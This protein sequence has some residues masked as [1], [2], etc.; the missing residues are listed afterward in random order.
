MKQLSLWLALFSCAV[1]ASLL[2]ESCT[3][4]DGVLDPQSLSKISTL[5][6]EKTSSTTPAA[7]PAITY[8]NNG[9]LMVMNADGS[10]QAVI[11]TA[12]NTSAQRPSWSP[13]AHNIVF[14]GTIGGVRG[15]WIVSVL[16]VNGKP[17]GSNLHRVQI[18][19]TG[20]P[21]WAK[22]SPVGDS[23][24]F[25]GGAYP[26]AND[27]N[28][29]LVAS[30]GGDPRILYT[31]ATTGPPSPTSAHCEYPTWSPDGT[32]LAFFETSDGG[33]SATHNLNVLDLNTKI[34]IT[35]VPFG[36][37]LGERTIAWSR[38]G[39]RI[40]YA[41]GTSK[42]PETIYTV[43]P[44]SNATPVS[45]F[46]GYSPTWSPD[47]LKLVYG[48]RAAIYSYTFSTGTR[49]TLSSGGTWPDWRRF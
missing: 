48:N 21:A 18:N 44:I 47:D 41:Y 15:M 42:L 31:A 14:S 13:D 26:G 27:P 35:V 24:V 36:T 30:T 43:T 1:L 10:N 45:L 23:I 16:V 49:Q 19:L 33:V 29:Y 3:K 7:D 11:A 6:V 4:K 17:T 38:Y 34:L 37:N 5:A 46:A 22:W 8:Q 39:D 20:N 25:I 40:A 32:K 12:D 28:I 2:P 9:D